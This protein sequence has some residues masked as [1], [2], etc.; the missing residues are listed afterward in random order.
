MTATT[1]TAAISGRP[2]DRSAFVAGY[3]IMAR[4]NDMTMI[5]MIYAIAWIP[6]MRNT[7]AVSR[8]T[9]PADRGRTG[10]SAILSDVF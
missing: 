8:S 9:V 4:I 5:V 1:A 2:L 6:M 10:V 7:A 3:T